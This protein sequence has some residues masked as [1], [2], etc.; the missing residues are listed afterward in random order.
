MVSCGGNT[1]SDDT[2]KARNRYR[3]PVEPS[4]HRARIVVGVIPF[5]LATAVGDR[6]LLPGEKP[7]AQKGISLAFSSQ[8]GCQTLT[9]LSGMMA[10]L[11]PFYLQFHIL[12]LRLKNIWNQFVDLSGITSDD[13]SSYYLFCG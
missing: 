7:E 5:I 10:K 1:N 6:E 12:K 2:G 13:L 9:V 8:A 4:Q 3:M 11:F